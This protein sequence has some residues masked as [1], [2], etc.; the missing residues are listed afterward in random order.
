[1]SFLTLLLDVLQL[2]LVLVRDAFERLVGMLDLLQLLVQ[3]LAVAGDL[4]QV[5]LDA[6]VF[7]AGALFRVLD[8]GFGQA[9]LA[10]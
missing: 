3:R 2:F 10:R 8:D 6:D 7:L 5:A 1:M 4:A 9:H